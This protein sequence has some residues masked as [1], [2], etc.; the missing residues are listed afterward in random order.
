MLVQFQEE[1]CSFSGPISVKLCRGCSLGSPGVGIPSSAQCGAALFLP[2]SLSWAHCSGVTSDGINLWEQCAPADRG[3]G[4]LKCGPD[5]KSTIKIGKCC[6][7]KMALIGKFM[8]GVFPT[9]NLAENGT[10][11]SMAVKNQGQLKPQ[12]C[13]VSARNQSHHGQSRHW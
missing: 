12:N 7:T 10:G 1:W 4:E 2:S 11:L 5:D 3:K 6:V 13:P 8:T 9:K